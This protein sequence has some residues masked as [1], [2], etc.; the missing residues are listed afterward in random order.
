[1]GVPGGMSGILSFEPRRRY[2]EKDKH[3]G[4]FVVID[5]RNILCKFGIGSLNTGTYI[6]NEKNQ[7]VIEIYICLIVAYKFLAEGIIPI[8]VFDG[9]SSADDTD[10]LVKRQNRKQKAQDHLKQIECIESDMNNENGTTSVV[11]R[12]FDN[13]K[14]IEI[15]DNINVTGIVLNDEDE[16][17]RKMEIDENNKNVTETDHCDKMDDENITEEEHI[18]VFEAIEDIVM[19]SNDTNN[20][21]VDVDV[22]KKRDFAI[23]DNLTD[24][25]KY[26]KQSFQLKTKNIEEGKRLLRK[27][28]VP[29]VDAPGKADPQCAA[30]AHVYAKNVIGVV[31]GD[32][33]M[34]MY[35][36]TNI[37]VMPSLGANYLEE[38]SMADTLQHLCDMM[39]NVINTSKDRE[40]KEKYKD[41]TIEFSHENLIDVGCLMGTDFCPGLKTKKYKERENDER[42]RI[43]IILELYAKNDMLLRK[44]LDKMKNIL[45]K[46]Y[47][48]KM[49]LA[50]DKFRN[51]PIHHPEKLKLWLKKPKPQKMREICS[52]F[53]D[54]DSIEHMISVVENTYEKHVKTN[55]VCDDNDEKFGSFLSYRRKYNMG[56]STSKTI[57]AKSTS[58]NK[59]WP[60]PM[61]RIPITIPCR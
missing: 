21:D 16:E 57:Q 26:L 52:S 10:T 19:K 23:K 39:I 27:M 35:L 41:K 30:I 55:Q 11:D 46:E 54:S 12:M 29:V 3:K 15:F 18:K 5:A 51:A 4:K 22:T 58:N 43:E 59:I 42:P 20:Y 31:T 17:D 40:L 49:Q 6:V 25:I 50:K 24:Y 34:L 48:T 44:V 33:D 2:H 47:I 36:S 53:I 37:L 9:A 13:I 7:N 45:S 8:F 56:R 32:F 38:Y 61:S 1:M 28:G 14:Q 60:E